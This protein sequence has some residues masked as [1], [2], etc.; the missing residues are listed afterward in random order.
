MVRAR[1]KPARHHMPASVGLTLGMLFTILLVFVLLVL[2]Y[3]Q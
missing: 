3:M 2:W 1:T